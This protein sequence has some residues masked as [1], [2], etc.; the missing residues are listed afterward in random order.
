[1]RKEVEIMFDADEIEISFADQA[2]T[3]TFDTAVKAET[4]ENVE[5]KK[6]KS[7]ATRD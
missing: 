6:Q 4:V 2:T 1:M 7:D 5:I 3:R